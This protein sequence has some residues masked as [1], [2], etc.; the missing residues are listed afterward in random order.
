M[1]FGE[2]LDFASEDE[3]LTEGDSTAVMSETVEGA[4][5]GFEESRRGWRS[6]FCGD[7]RPIA[8]PI[9][10]TAWTGG[11]LVSIVAAST[12]SAVVTTSA[13]DLVVSS[14]TGILVV[15]SATLRSVVS[16]TANGHCLDLFEVLLDLNDSKDDSQFRLCSDGGGRLM[17]QLKL[18]K[19]DGYS[20]FSDLMI[21]FRC[22]VLTTT[23]EVSARRT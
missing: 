8:E 10:G 12:G 1:V 6:C 4:G 11:S 9:S 3:C 5:G 13:G 16:A 17:E 20:E 22:C 14:S 7:W 23:D 2:G 21:F 19:K 18:G 15:A